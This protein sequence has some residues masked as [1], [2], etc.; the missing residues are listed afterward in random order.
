[1]TELTFKELL[2]LLRKKWWFV[3][4]FTSLALLVSGYLSFFY[5]TP[6]YVNSSTL[7]VND[8]EQNQQ[9]NIRLDDIMLYEKLIGTY[10]DIIKSKRIL[11]EAASKFELSYEQLFGM[12]SVASRTNSQI[13]TISVMHSDYTKATNLA[14]FIA[15]TFR[16]R[17]PEIMTVDNVQILDPADQKANPHPVKPNKTMNLA[18]ALLLG[19]LFSSVLVIVFYFIDTRIRSDEEFN[20][21][22]EYPI[23]GSI[24]HYDKKSRRN[25]NY[26]GR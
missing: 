6:Q 17:L 3:I 15:E 2:L 21:L 25:S 7:L 26:L 13:I 1:M 16:L 11:G 19:F 24:P 23:L 14:N 12:V 22:V 20:L 4:T 9:N 18:L 10:K 5:F 8:R